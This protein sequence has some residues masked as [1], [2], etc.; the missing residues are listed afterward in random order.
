MADELNTVLRNKRLFKIC[1]AVKLGLRYYYMDAKQRYEVTPV[2]RDFALRIIPSLQDGWLTAKYPWTREYT[3]KNK[4]E[5]AARS[6]PL[7][8]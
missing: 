1:E 3:K 2:L 5:K 6:R 8:Y 4:S 7:L